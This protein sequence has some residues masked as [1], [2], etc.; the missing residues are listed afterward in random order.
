MADL[1]DYCII[2][3]SDKDDEMSSDEDSVYSSSTTSSSCDQPSTIYVGKFPS[4]INEGQ[5]RSHFQQ[6]SPSITKVTIVRDKETKSSKGFAFIQFNSDEVAD[7]AI[8][9]LNRSKLL[10]KYV[11]NVKNKKEQSSR[12]G[13]GQSRQSLIKVWVGNISPDTTK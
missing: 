11:I 2:V 6:F 8:I 7:R 13:K 9:S 10:D 3:D 5:L 4:F 12:K 1:T